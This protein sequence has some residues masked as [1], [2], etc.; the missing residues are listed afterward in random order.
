MKNITIFHLKINIVFAAVKNC[1][2]LKHRRVMYT[3]ANILAN[4]KIIS[5]FE[6][7]GKNSKK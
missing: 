4:M 5:K 7:R 3:C 2:I 6:S 1:S